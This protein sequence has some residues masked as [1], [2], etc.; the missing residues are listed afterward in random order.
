MLNGQGH[1]AMLT[2][3]NLFAAEILAFL[4]AAAGEPA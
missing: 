4:G 1:V 3:P 2:A